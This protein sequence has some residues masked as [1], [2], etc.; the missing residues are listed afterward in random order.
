MVQLRMVDGQL[1]VKDPIRDYMFRGQALDRWNYL[2]FILGTY[3]GKKKERT[4]S[5]RRPAN[6]RVLYQDDDSRGNRCR[7][8]RSHDHET[9]PYVPGPWFPKRDETKVNK[10]FEA[11]MLAFLKPWRSLRDLKTGTESFEDA[12]DEFIANATADVLFTVQNI[13]YFHECCK[14][15]QEQNVPESDDFNPNCHIPFDHENES[16]VEEPGT[17]TG[18]G[19]PA[20]VDVS[21]DDIERALENP[22]SGREQLYAHLAIEIGLETG[23]LDDR[24]CDIVLDEHASPATAE[25]LVSFQQ[26][27]DALKKHPGAFIDDFDECVHENAESLDGDAR[28]VDI[29][30]I[31][32]LRSP[33]HST[34]TAI[35]PL[36]CE[37]TRDSA[38]LNARQQMACDIVTEHLN[39]HLAGENPSQRLLIVHGPGGTGKSTLLNEISRI[40]ADKRAS[41]LLAKTATTG[42]AASIIGGSTLHSWAALPV[43]TPRSDNWINQPGKEVENRR[44]RNVG[45]VLWLIIDE[46]SMLT[47]PTLVHLSQLA[48]T[49]RAG[50]A[51]VDPGTPFGGISILLSGDFHQ[52]PPVAS[53]KKELYHS[54]PPNNLCLIGRNLYEQFN[55]VVGLQEQ[56]RIQDAVWNGILH[57]ARTGECTSDDITEIRKLVLTDAQCDVPDFSKAPWNECIL[58]TPRNSV[59]TSWNKFALR[60]HCQRTRRLCYIIDADDSIDGRPLTPVQ[61]LAIANM[62]TDETNHLPNRIE[63]A[64]GMKIMVLLNLATDADLANGSR[65]IITDIVLHPEEECLQKGEYRV[66]LK[67]PPSVIFFKSYQH[68]TKPIPGLPEGIIPIFP[69]RKTFT[70]KEER[71][72]TISRLQFALTPAY[73]FTD[74]KSQGQTIEHVIVDLAKPPS[75]SLTAFNAYVALSRS[76]GRSTI[77]LLRPFDEKLFTV[78][79]SEELRKEDERLAVLAQKT[80]E[81]YEHGEFGEFGARVPVSSCEMLRNRSFT[82]V[83]A[84]R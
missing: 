10:L 45:K 31:V 20:I 60:E 81:R 49:V 71:R 21:E 66:H 23:A 33:V 84:M 83:L 27:E 78:H 65:G 80:I 57:R 6:T 17:G 34:V 50:I 53:P 47:T 36:G 15:A 76:R 14:S 41:A 46:M 40:F 72:R 7:I 62:K 4:G 18:D 58:V 55:I 39:R 75:G 48:G 51:S 70:L 25:Q 56:V 44:K 38:M 9:M 82:N 24:E 79:P 29:A 61:R 35:A 22:F 8:I 54:M 37:S 11:A 52:F 30:K 26:W 32:T 68:Q 5:D 1:K 42:V 64:I 77:R 13:E 63:V 43:K 3:D 28:I 12:F 69:T 59:R 16:Y 73:A 67:H 2:D 19:E 74:F